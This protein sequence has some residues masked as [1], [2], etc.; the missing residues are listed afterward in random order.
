MRAAP[1]RHCESFVTR[2]VQHRPGRADRRPDHAA[3]MLAAFVRRDLR[4]RKAR[5]LVTRG[6]SM[7]LRGGDAGTYTVGYR[8]GFTDLFDS[9]KARLSRGGPKVRH[10]ACTHGRTH[11]PWSKRG[12]NHVRGPRRPHS[13]AVRGRGDRGH[14]PHR[15][16]LHAQR[17]LADSLQHIGRSHRLALIDLPIQR[18]DTHHLLRG[19]DRKDAGVGSASQVINDFSTVAPL[20]FSHSPM[21]LPASCP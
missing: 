1:R 17:R 11:R 14:V 21:S 8:W 4:L 10:C 19:S 7:R 13:H 12:D 15:S 9:E 3:G 16:N 6:K 18:H 2:A 20:A 5:L